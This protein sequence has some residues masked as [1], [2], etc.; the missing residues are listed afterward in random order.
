MQIRWN[1]RRRRRRAKKLKK[2]RKRNPT[3]L[4]YACCEN[5]HSGRRKRKATPRMTQ[6][7]KKGTKVA[8]NQRKLWTRPTPATN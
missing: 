6:A 7:L 5:S 4:S 1:K 8:K 3:M 2:R